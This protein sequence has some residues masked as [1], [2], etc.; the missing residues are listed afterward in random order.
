M[1]YASELVDIISSKKISYMEIPVNIKYTEYSLS[2]WQK[3][4]NAIYIALK[5]IWN[6]FFK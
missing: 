1:S 4:S 2:K 3:N 5:M 6:K